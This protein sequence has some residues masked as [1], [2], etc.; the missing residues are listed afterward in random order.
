MTDGAIDRM[1]RVYE[2]HLDLLLAEELECNLRFARW[3]LERCVGVV[4]DGEID[5][6]VIVGHVDDMVGDASN[7]GEDDL[8]IEA[9][10]AAGER[11]VVLVENKIDAVFQERQVERYLARA[12]RHRESASASAVAAVAPHGFFERHRDSLTD[13]VC[14]SVEEIAEVLLDRAAATSD[15]TSAR[16]KWRASRLVHL[17]EVRGTPTATYPPTVALRDWLILA[18][19]TLDPTIEPDAGSMRTANTRWLS[20]RDPSAVKFK[21]GHDCVDI[22]LGQ[23]TMSDQVDDLLASVAAPDGFVDT[24][25]TA[26]NRILRFGYRPVRTI[27]ELWDDGPVDEKRLLELTDACV[28][29]CA[30]VRRVVDNAPAR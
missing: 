28:R 17:E 25:D 18:I 10:S 29:A 2:R 23:L 6:S 30:W 20:I 24:V 4:P 9:R 22:Y 21:V 7:A 26:G 12:E 8:F 1:R 13:V 19:H 11:L 16:L 27:D 3:F 15:G 14:I 5:V